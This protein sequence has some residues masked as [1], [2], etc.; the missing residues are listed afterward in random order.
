MR[1]GTQSDDE[2]E[3]FVTREYDRL[4]RIA[5][6][7]TGNRHDAEDLVQDSLAKLL[8]HW[9]KVAATASPTSY[10]RRTIVNTFLSGKRRRAAS[11]IVSTE[12]VDHRSESSDPTTQFIQRHDLLSAVLT[13]PPSQRVVIVLRYL[14]DLPVPEVARILGKREGAVRATCHRGLEKLRE[15]DGPPAVTATGRAAHA[16]A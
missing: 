7:L 14:E 10:A 11:E 9:D 15:P 4:R 5:I 8:V 12:V 13:L 3:Q 1:Q 16:R 6:S 2:F